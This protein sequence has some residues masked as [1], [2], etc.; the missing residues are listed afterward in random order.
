[1][2]NLQR[3]I[4]VTRFISSKYTRSKVRKALP[5][6]FEYIIDELLNINESLQNK[7]AYFSAIIETIIQI[8]RANAF[9]IAICK[10][11]QRL[12]IDRLH[13]VGDIFDRGPNAEKVME[14]KVF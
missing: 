10:L 14:E 13:V 11:I 4:E 12:V 5:K 9:I 8:G 6:D 3:L 2:I 7:E 1:M